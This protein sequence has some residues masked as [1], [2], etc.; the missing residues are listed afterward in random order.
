MKYL[1]TYES[2][3]RDW[4]K[5]MREENSKPKKGD[6]VVINTNVLIS[7]KLDFLINKIGIIETS[8]IWGRGGKYDRTEYS[9]GFDVKEK[10]MMSGKSSW[11]FEQSDF[12][13][14]SKDEKELKIKIQAN[15]Y[16]I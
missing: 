4:L 3:V 9:I 12:L 11:D 15:K 14:F 13:A 6:Y 10:N 1:K 16:N 2:Q 8:T 5:Q 7:K